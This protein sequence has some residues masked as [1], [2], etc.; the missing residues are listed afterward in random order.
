[1]E[2]IKTQHLFGRISILFNQF[3]ISL[4]FCVLIFIDFYGLISLEY[5]IYFILCY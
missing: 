5:V 3:T 2:T 4:L 1:M